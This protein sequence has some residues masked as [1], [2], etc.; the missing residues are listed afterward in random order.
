MSEPRARTRGSL[1]VAGDRC[2]KERSLAESSII[3]GR[4]GKGVAV[5]PL[6][7]EERSRD[8]RV[9]G[10]VAVVLLVVAAVASY[11]PAV[12]ATRVDPNTALRAD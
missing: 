10:G 3:R 12:R 9:L 2:A 1:K 6:L 5:E 4:A 11:L 7:F 8:P